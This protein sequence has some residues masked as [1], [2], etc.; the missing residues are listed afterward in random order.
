MVT[1]YE[2]LEAVAGVAADALVLHTGGGTAAEFNH[3]RPGPANLD[4]AVGSVTPMALG[5]SLALPR[6]RVV[7][8]ETDGGILLNLSVLPD[9]GNLRPPRLTVV[10]FDNEVYESTGGQPSATSGRADLAALAGAAGVEKTAT[11]R[12]REEFERTVKEALEDSSCHFIVAKVEVGAKRVPPL[13]ISGVEM[14]F[15][16]V[17]HIEETEGVRVLSPPEQRIPEHLVRD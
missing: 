3:L 10:V 11:A 13:E 17:R 15:R 12:S 1:R 16:F 4:C 7:A 6:R 8:L 9:L 2:C 5:L 14:K